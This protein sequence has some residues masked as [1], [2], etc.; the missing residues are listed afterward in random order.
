VVVPLTAYLTEL[1]PDDDRLLACLGGRRPAVH[2]GEDVGIA[3]VEL[4]EVAV[5][6]RRE[7]QRPLVLGDG[8]AVSAEIGR[9][10]VTDFVRRGEPY[11][12]DFRRASRLASCG[13]SVTVMGL[14]ERMR[15]LSFEPSYHII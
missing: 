5:V 8:L 14:L 13:P 1:V 3:V 2:H 4:G 7:P 6:G 9:T 15:R 11:S 12:P 10:A